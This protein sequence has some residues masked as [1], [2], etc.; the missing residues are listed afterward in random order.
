MFVF[1][2]CYLSVSTR[3]WKALYAWQ[4][5]DIEIII[6]ARR[7]SDPNH[8]RIPNLHTA[9]SNTKPSMAHL[10]GIMKKAV[11]ST[12][13]QIKYE[14]KNRSRLIHPLPTMLFRLAHAFVPLC[15]ALLSLLTFFLLSHHPDKT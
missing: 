7:T 8:V 6:A 12:L 13:N 11:N 9:I 3:A 10:A 2:V 5:H 14:R 1:S 4:D 15:Q